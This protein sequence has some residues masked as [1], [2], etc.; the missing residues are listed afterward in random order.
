MESTIIDVALLQDPWIQLTGQK[1]KSIEGFVAHIM[2]VIMSVLKG[3]T[4]AVQLSLEFL[5]KMTAYMMILKFNMGLE[6]SIT[7]H[8]LS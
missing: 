4:A 7:C 5:L 6:P 2:M 1:A 8:K 3:Y